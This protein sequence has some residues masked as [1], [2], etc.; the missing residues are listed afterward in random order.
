MNLETDNR[1]RKIVQSCGFSRNTASH[2]HK[3]ADE[4]G[5][6]WPLDASQTD[7]VLET[8]LYPKGTVDT[9]QNVCQTTIISERNC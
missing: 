7:K 5:L 9:T 3:R 2:T 4:M 1:E 6:K 8:R